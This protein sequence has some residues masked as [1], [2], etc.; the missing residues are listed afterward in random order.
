MNKN[1]LDH[2]NISGSAD[3]TKASIRKKAAATQRPDNARELFRKTLSAFFPDAKVAGP[4]FVEKKD[5]MAKL[6][7]KVRDDS[8]AL[9]L[10]LMSIWQ[11]RD[12]A[13]NEYEVRRKCLQ[14]AMR[15]M[16]GAKVSPEDMQ[17][18]L[19]NDPGLYLQAM[20]MRPVKTDS[21]EYESISG[22][23]D[24]ESNV[25][26]D[27]MKNGDKNLVTPGFT[28]PIAYDTAV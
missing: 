20:L 19:E 14:I 15:L 10:Q 2:I 3:A 28:T 27:P 12:A 9:K 6:L 17:F 5:S 13:E 25:S 7:D 26:F 1:S 11:Q 4:L 24:K 21:E 22:D 23:E 18:L 8:E 16:K